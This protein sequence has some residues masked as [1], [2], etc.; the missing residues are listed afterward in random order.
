ML[1]VEVSYAQDFSRH[2]FRLG[3]G[4]PM[5][6]KA[7]FYESPTRLSYHYSGHFFADYSYFITKWLS[8]GMNI[9][10]ENVSWKNE[11]SKEHFSNYTFL[12][13]VRFTYFRKGMVTMYSGIGVGMTVNTG[14]EETFLGKT[15]CSPAFGL[16][17][18]G[19]SVGKGHFFG[20]FDL[21]GLF[22]LRSTQQIFMIGSRLLS[23][24]VG[25][26]L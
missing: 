21:G 13:N 24:S 1:S 3:W 20:A 26:R 15:L 5:F 10:F 23:F 16:T 4:D 14:S 12:P 6:E 25:Y 7:V 18:Y 2:E 8:V 17:A 9:D 11:A 22:A 19:I